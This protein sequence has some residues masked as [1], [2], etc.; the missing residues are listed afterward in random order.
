MAQR[1]TP[2]LNGLPVSPESK[3]TV[4]KN[5]HP[6]TSISVEGDKASL[7]M[8]VERRV[9]TL[10]DL[11]REAKIDTAEWEVERFTCNKWEVALKLGEKKKESVHV[12]DLWQVKA[13]LV[14][15]K[16]ALLLREIGDE[17]IR[18]VKTHAPV[19]ARISHQKPKEPCLAEI[20][21]FDLHLGK[22]AWGMESGQNY[23]LKIATELYLKTLSTIV[24]RVSSFE[25]ERF[26]FP[27]GNDFFNVNSSDNET[28]A[29]TPQ[30]ED[31]RWK[32][33]FA[34]GWSL[35]ADSIELLS[36]KAPVDVIVIP[37]NHDFESAFYMG[38]VLSARFSKDKNVN[39]DNSPPLRK[40]Y[41]YGA[42]LIGFAHGKDEKLAQLP[43]IMATENAQEFA[44][45]KYREWHVGDQHRK[46]EYQWLATSEE[47]GVTVRI[48]RSLAATDEWHYRKGYIGNIR[49]GEAF[50]WHKTDGLICNLSVNL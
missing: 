12:Q 50:I 8:L 6:H 20:A 16:D 7:D 15:R 30:S 5:I 48:L 24:D 4:K 9:K 31:D 11:I 45:T 43:M 40:Y 25:V 44:A 33:T 26:V 2:T 47:K 36:K 17:I 39:V 23:D 14:R 1:T 32:K 27:V 19:V 42:N 28:F 13:T 38:E 10:E 35:M 37:G 29:G 22:L 3:K 34:K 49:A 18:Q 41:R 21:F 46:K